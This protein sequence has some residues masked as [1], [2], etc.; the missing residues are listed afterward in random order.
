VNDTFNNRGA[1]CKNGASNGIGGYL[2][3]STGG[4]ATRDAFLGVEL[5]IFVKDIEDVRRIKTEAIS[6]NERHSVSVTIGWE[7]VHVNKPGVEGED[8]GMNRTQ[9]ESVWLMGTRGVRLVEDHWSAKDGGEGAMC[10]GLAK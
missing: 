10:L 5:V 6:E 1:S 9:V 8:L 4:V 2:D 3:H 7:T